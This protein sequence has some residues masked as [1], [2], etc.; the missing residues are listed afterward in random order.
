MLVTA[1]ERQKKNNSR[2]NV[3]IDGEF[4]AGLT[5]FAVMSCGLKVGKEVDETFLNEVVRKSECDTCFGYL[6]DYISHYTRSVKQ[7]KQKLFEKEFS[8]EASEYAI[9]KALSYGY[10]SDERYAR[11]YTEQKKQKYGIRKIRYDLSGDG[12]DKE[13]IDEVCDY[14][15]VPFALAAAQKRGGLVETTKDKEKLIRFL[16]SRGFGYDS[17]KLVIDCIKSGENGEEN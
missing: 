15:E 7:L 14:D 17:V 5:D 12:I 10:V 9:E 16:Q 11:A 2:V 13:L 3:F 1:I 8:Q 4:F 6:V